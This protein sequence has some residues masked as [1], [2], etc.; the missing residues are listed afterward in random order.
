MNTVIQNIEKNWKENFMLHASS[1]I[2]VSTCI[3]GIA[4]M[5]I[6]QNGTGI[7]QLIQLIIVVVLCNAV[8]VAILSVQKPKMVLYTVIASLV[9]CTLIAFANF[10]F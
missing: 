9:L 4:A 7:F 1:A 3:G 8:L 5:S 6:L 2:I 10:M